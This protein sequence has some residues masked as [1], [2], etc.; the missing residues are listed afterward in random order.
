[1][2]ARRLCAVM[3]RSPTA[4]PRVFVRPQQRGAFGSKTKGSS[5]PNFSGTPDAK[6]L[7]VRAFC[8][9]Q[10]SWTI[11][12][13]AVVG[14]GF[15]R[16]AVEAV[17]V[18]V[19]VVAVWAQAD[20]PAMTRAAATSELTSSRFND[21]CI[22]IASSGIWG[23]ATRFALRGL[24]RHARVAFRQDLGGGEGDTVLRRIRRIGD[25][26]LRRRWV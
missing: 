24:R 4:C 5:L 11:R 26:G 2:T 8:R 18:E 12:S 7:A 1:M 14:F 16:N 23:S 6:N 22:F 17:G 13:D 20:R 21:V 9:W 25:H 3:P 19:V 15:D 10:A